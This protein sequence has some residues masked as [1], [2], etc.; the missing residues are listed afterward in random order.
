MIKEI[1]NKEEGIKLYFKNITISYFLL[2]FFSLFN[3]LFEFR[4]DNK[5]FYFVY[6]FEFF[7]LFSS[8][9]AFFL[10]I[11]GSKSL[12]KSLNKKVLLTNFIIYPF[13]IIFTFV[14][15]FIYHYFNKGGN[16][17]IGMDMNFTYL[18]CFN[19]F[20]IYMILFNIKYQY[21]FKLDYKK[22]DLNT[23][24]EL[25]IGV[26]KK[27]YDLN[28]LNKMKNIFNTIKYSILFIFTF[29]GF[30]ILINEII[31]N[32]IALFIWILI[33]LIWL[34]IILIIFFIKN[35][36]IKTFN[37][38]SIILFSI[39][40][41]LIGLYFVLSAYIFTKCLEIERGEFSILFS[42]SLF[43]VGL[44]FQ[45]IINLIYPYYKLFFKLNIK[46]EE[47]KIYKEIESKNE[48]NQES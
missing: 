21:K 3:G 5:W 22:K 28:E 23:V 37:Y 35:H 29:I 40:L 18:I 7:F 27:E 30:G 44:F 32:N 11:K 41:T 24:N 15:N 45:G 6:L 8:L 46:K 20:L 42:I 16:N 9:L 12:S 13:Y 48:E 19:I 34:L 26:N 1:N 39:Y 17:I 33:N 38:K 43:I 4:L 10:S 25:L 14:Y 47:D 31:K 36:K 2:I